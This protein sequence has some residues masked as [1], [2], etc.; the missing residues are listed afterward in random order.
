MA[1][2]RILT[3]ILFLAAWQEAVT[4]VPVHF[5]AVDV[6]QNLTLPC[7]E[8]DA[9]PQSGGTIGV[10]WIREGREDEQIGRLKVESNGALE[11]INVSAD[12]AGNYSCTLDDDHDAV[13][14]RINVQVRTPPPALHNVWVKPST[15]LANIL[16]EV[17]GTGGY[18][19]IDFTAEYR[20]KPNVGEE[21]EDWKPI[22][23]THIP[24]NSR[25]IDVYHLVPNTTYSFRV[26]ATNQL[27]RGEI[28]E[29][30]GH[31]H[32]SVEELELARH[33]LSGVENFDTRV[34][35]AAVG[36]VMGTLMILG[37][38]TCYLLYRECKVPSQL[39][40]QEVIELVPNI[41]LNPGF[42]DER[43]EHIPQDENFNNQTTTR[44]NNN[45]VV[46]PRRL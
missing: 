46:Q 19:I 20:L 27:G 12:D 2:H 5:V 3:L 28:V 44:L 37:I 45:S 39:E 25:Q 13:K 10:L 35:V 29:V 4:L 6:G 36:I 8:E 17:A 26:W 34:W 30:E 24:P 16:W 9:L 42:F 40:E 1:G 14:T 7:A 22:V 21:P 31:T 33:L 23:P 18:P 41:I 43:T 38:G 32:H 11:L 15:I